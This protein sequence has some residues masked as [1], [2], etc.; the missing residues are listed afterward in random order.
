MPDFSECAGLLTA[1]LRAVLFD[2]AAWL[3]QSLFPAA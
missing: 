1:G 3:L 2:A